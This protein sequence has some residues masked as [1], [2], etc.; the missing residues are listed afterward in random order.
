MAIQGTQ[1]GFRLAQEK[2]KLSSGPA[3][4]HPLHPTAVLTSPIVFA[5]TISFLEFPFMIS[6]EKKMAEIM[7]DKYEW[8]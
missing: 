6:T 3:A 4:P 8:S 7:E 1:R 5:D 2:V